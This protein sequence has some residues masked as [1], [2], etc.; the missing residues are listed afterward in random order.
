MFCMMTFDFFQSSHINHILF[1][2]SIIWISSVRINVHMTVFLKLYF[3][4]IHAGI[5]LWKGS[6][7]EYNT[8]INH[9]WP[10]FSVKRLK[11]RLIKICLHQ[12]NNI[13]QRWAN[14]YVFRADIFKQVSINKHSGFSK[15]ILTYL[16]RVDQRAS[17]SIGVTKPPKV[18][19][20][21]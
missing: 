5:L 15:K 4:I 7:G 8:Y 12:D 10:F 13:R 19:M 20:C 3:L 11:H 9:A 21:A 17:H 14:S 18:L 2:D 16:A 1:V 6:T